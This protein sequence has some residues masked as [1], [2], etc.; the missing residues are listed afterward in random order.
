MSRWPGALVY[1]FLR[2]NAVRVFPLRYIRL[3]MADIADEYRRAIEEIQRRYR[4]PR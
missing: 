2:I 3:S 4:V 1:P